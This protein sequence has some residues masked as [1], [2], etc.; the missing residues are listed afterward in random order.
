MSHIYP[1]PTLSISKD[2]GFSQLCCPQGQSLGLE[3]PQGQNNQRLGLSLEMKV[4]AMVLRQKV[5]ELSCKTFASLINL[6][7]IS[8]K[9]VMFVEMFVLT[10]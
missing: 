4:L 9:V 1:A 6:F 5:L 7:C 3:V 10:E 8:S 2:V